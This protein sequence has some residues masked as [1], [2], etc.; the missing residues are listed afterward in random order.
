MERTRRSTIGPIQ[1]RRFTA[2]LWQ[3]SLLPQLRDLQDV[4]R[5]LIFSA[6]NHPEQVDWAV[7][8]EP[9][10]R[11]R[12]LR[13]VIDHGLNFDKVDFIF[14]LCGGTIALR[15]KIALQTQRGR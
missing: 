3:L 9:V 2:G 5:C 8:H 6:A 12:H 10:A 1:L 14:E 4:D 11:H 7:I 15:I 13:N